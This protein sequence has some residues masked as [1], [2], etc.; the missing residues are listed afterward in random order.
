MQAAGQAAKEMCR[1]QPGNSHQLEGHLHSQSS[2][3]VEQYMSA[4][5]EPVV[6]ASTLPPAVDQTYLTYNLQLCYCAGGSGQGFG[7][8]S[9]TT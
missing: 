3:A 4:S 7:G 1:D 5:S 2:S 9:G 8:R 6:Y